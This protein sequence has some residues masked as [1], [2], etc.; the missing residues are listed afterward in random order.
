MVKSYVD[1]NLIPIINDL[2]GRDRAVVFT[3]PGTVMLNWH[4]EQKDG[5]L[6]KVQ[7]INDKRLYVQAVLYDGPAAVAKLGPF[8]S[9]F[10]NYKFNYK[11]K[12]YS[13]DVRP[14]TA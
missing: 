3:K 11:G 8:Y 6:I 9:F 2:L 5:L 7:I 10:N 13:A 14:E 1:S 12:K 4:V